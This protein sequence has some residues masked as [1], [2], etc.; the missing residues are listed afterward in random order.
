VKTTTDL[1][2]KGTEALCLPAALRHPVSREIV[3]SEVTRA[4]LLDPIDTKIGNLNLKISNQIN[5]TR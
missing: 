5:Q 4:N 3:K 2:R 1:D